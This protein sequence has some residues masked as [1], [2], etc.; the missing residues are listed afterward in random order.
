MHWTISKIIENS[1]VYPE[2]AFQ[3]GFWGLNLD[4]GVFL[5]TTLPQV[6]N[7]Q[8][9]KQQGNNKDLYEV[10]I[11]RCKL[12]DVSTHELKNQLH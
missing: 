9:G 5:V 4:P 3:L 8:K 10:E 6:L 2:M 7:V 12:T 11:N 1:V